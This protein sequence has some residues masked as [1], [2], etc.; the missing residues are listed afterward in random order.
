V[1]VSSSH[2]IWDN[3]PIFAEESELQVEADTSEDR[4]M[5]RKP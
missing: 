5:K 4:K 1:Q 3:S 2:E